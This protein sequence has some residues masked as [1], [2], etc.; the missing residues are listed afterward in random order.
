LA[1]R[2]AELSETKHIGAYL[3]GTIDP[4]WQAYVAF[5]LD[6]LGCRFCRAN[7]DDLRRQT[8]GEESRTLERQILQSTVGFLRRP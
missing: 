4:P 1:R 7:L 3:L 5:H 8:A 2:T 6:R